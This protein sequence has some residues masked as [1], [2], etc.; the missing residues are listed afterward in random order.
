MLL[1]GSLFDGLYQLSG[2]LGCCRILRSKTC[3]LILTRG[4]QRMKS[5]WAPP[6]VAYRRLWFKQCLSSDALRLSA[7][8]LVA[9]SSFGMKL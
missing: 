2:S 7:V 5:A 1:L 4:R 8:V 3:P 6:K 9:V